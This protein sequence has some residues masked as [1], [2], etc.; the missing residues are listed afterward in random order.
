MFGGLKG[1]GG[2]TMTGALGIITRG[3][4]F[5]GFLLR[6]FSQLRACCAKNAS[7]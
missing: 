2:D 3:R 4:L 6:G 7:L 1:R 5:Q